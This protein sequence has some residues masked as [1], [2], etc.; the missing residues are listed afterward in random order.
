MK[1]IDKK[2]IDYCEFFSQPDS[3]ILKELEQYTFKNKQLPQMISGN[4]VGNFL[5]LLIHS[6]N[7]KKILEVG[8]FTAYSAIKMAQSNRGCEIH[9]CEVMEKHVKTA[10]KFIRKAKL[11]QNITV[12]H[13][14]AIETL[15]TFKTGYFDFA[16]IDADKVNYLEY[17]KRIVTLIKTG[18]VIVLDNMLWSGE[19]IEPKNEQ[20]KALNKTAQFI[21]SDNRVF[22]TLLPIRDGLM[23]CYKK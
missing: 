19:V 16:F 23:I 12:H 4:M 21:Q 17:Y 5:H 9:T 22:N 7:A 20:S 13:G 15:E 11:D 6:M 2:I 3:E 10:R 8:T 18:G 14:Q 1:F